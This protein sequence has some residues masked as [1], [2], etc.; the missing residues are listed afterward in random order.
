MARKRFAGFM[1]NC[2]PSMAKKFKEAISRGEK[3][4]LNADELAFY[5]ALANNNEAVVLDK[6]KR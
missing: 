1:R 6:W 3:L 2:K 4:A 5:N